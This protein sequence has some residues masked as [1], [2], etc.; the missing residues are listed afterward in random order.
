M[1]CCIFLS[2]LLKDKSVPFFTFLYAPVRASPFS[3]YFSMFKA[4]HLRYTFNFCLT[5][6]IAGLVYFFWVY[7]FFSLC[8]GRSRSIIATHSP[9]VFL[10]CN[11][12]WHRIISF[13]FIAACP[14]LFIEESVSR[15]YMYKA[16]LSWED[17][18]A[19]RELTTT[20]EFQHSRY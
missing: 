2:S 1:R 5:L 13:E 19:C 18:R 8:S 12:H 9:L 4:A 11:L 6:S 15:I 17:R 14:F 16:R 10:K 3:I 7:W 20:V